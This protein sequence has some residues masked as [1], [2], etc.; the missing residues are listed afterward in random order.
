MDRPARETM[1][2]GAADERSQPYQYL[3]ADPDAY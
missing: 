1:H 2:E 3:Q